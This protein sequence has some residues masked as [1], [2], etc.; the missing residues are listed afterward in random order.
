MASWKRKRESSPIPDPA[1]AEP[2]DSIL[3]EAVGE[4]PVGVATNTSFSVEISYQKGIHPKDATKK[5]DMIL[6]YSVYPE[7]HW[8][9]LIGYENFTSTPS[10]F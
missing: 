9:A 3:N 5:E 6:V 1:L 10:P 4:Q 2:D 7:S 8:N